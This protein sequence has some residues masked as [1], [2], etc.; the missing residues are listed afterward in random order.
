MRA[1]EYVLIFF[2]P[3]LRVVACCIYL[4]LL[5]FVGKKTNGNIC[6]MSE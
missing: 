6:R 1:E 5:D 2:T 3:E 4:T